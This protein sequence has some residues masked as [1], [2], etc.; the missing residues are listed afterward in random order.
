MKLALVY[1]TE[2]QGLPLFSQ[3][4]DDPRQ[5]HIVQLGARLI[6]LDKREIISTLD[7]VIRPDGWE[8]PYEVAAIHGI[9]TERATLVG[10]SEAAALEVFLDMWSRAGVRIGHNEIFDSRIIRIAQKRFGN[11]N[12]DAW[13]KGLAECTAKMATPI[14][15]LPPTAKMVAAGRHHPKT[16]NLGEAYRFFTGHELEGA[17]S[18]LVDVDACIACYYAM[19]DV[20]DDK[21]A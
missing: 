16:P 10:I 13:Q 7:V 12:T 4:S 11:T 15:K 20:E 18:A 5:P 9:T 6:D 1:D 14:I 3:P 19:T 21:A 8:I 2:T 17:H